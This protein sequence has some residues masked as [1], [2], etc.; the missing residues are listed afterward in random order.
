LGQRPF[1]LGGEQAL[2]LKF[3]PELEEGELERAQAFGLHV[4]RD[5]LVL[6][7]R[8][9]ERYPA[10]QYYLEAVLRFELE[11]A[12]AGAEEYRLYLGVFVF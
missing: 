3:F 4:F 12:A 5:Y 10:A 9:V 6:A 7:A 8:L 2:L 1:P 11:E